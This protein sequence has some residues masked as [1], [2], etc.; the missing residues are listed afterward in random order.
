M[1]SVAIVI[2]LLATALFLFGNWARPEMNHEPEAVPEPHPDVEPS[3]FLSKYRPYDS[4][5]LLQLIQLGNVSQ[6]EATAINRI[7]RERNVPHVGVS[8]F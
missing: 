1:N 3:E 8:L 4:T 5:R 2:V 6:D 7:L